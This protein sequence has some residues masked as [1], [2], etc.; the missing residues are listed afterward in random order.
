MRPFLL[1]KAAGLSTF[2][3]A[4]AALIVAS[5][6]VQAAPR[7]AVVVVSEGLN[8]Q[9][10]DMGKTYLDYVA[11]V[12][13]KAEE[14]EVVPSAL[15]NL[16]KGTA[17]SSVSLS[18]MRGLLKNAAA[19][20]YKTGLITTGDASKAAALFYDV[21]GDDVA[22]AL[23][24]STRFDFLAGGGREN[25]LPKSTAGSTRKDETD[26][27][28]T[29]RKAGGT[30]VMDAEAAEDATLEI[31]GKTVILQNNGS[32]DYALD[33]RPGVQQS[34]SVLA[35][36]AMDALNGA[37][38]TTPYLLVV[39]DDLVAKALAAK[40]T[41]ALFGQIRELNTVVDQAVSARSIMETPDDLAVALIGTGGNVAARFTSEEK[42]QHTN[43]LFITSQLG[44]SY[45]GAG[46][47]L[48]GADAE[49]VTAFT[50]D[51]YK[52]WKLSAS[53]KTDL[54]AGTLGGE[55]AVRAAYEPAI[56][57]AYS[58][59][60]VA[61]AV[62]TLGVDGA[63]IVNTLSAMAKTKAPAVKPVAIAATK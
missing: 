26:L 48:K 39:H 9:L 14:G 2:A 51:D 37:D 3:L 61:S 23:V 22:G 12:T 60:D 34:L 15:S 59:T 28:A 55:T 45:E 46:R 36:T 58:T 13:A 40:D 42:A 21:A 57:I 54:V 10:V 43:A 32:M 35:S 44:Y 5:S 18:A 8:P 62:Y 49:A 1:S 11:D 19:N 7:Q 63:D 4:S 30:A 53:D 24:S 29:L 52:G 27:A 31:K 50:T 56:G 38:D 16:K 47:K 25:F 33:Q 41:P 20:G 17:N 6:S